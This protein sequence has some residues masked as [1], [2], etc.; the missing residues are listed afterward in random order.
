MSHRSEGDTM[1]E[2]HALQ[3][4]LLAGLVVGSTA[5]DLPVDP[6]SDLA[7]AAPPA[8]LGPMIDTGGD[9][10]ARQGSDITGEFDLTARVSSQFDNQ[11]VEVPM[12]AVADQSGEIRTGMATVELELRP[13]DAPQQ[14]GASTDQ[15]EPIDESGAFQATVTGFT[16]PADSS[17]MLQKD[18]TADVDLDAQIVDSD[19]FRGDSTITM[20][21]VEVSGSTIPEVVLEGPFTAHRPG[22]SCSG[23]SKGD[24]G[25]TADTD[26]GA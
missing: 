2:T 7:D 21:D 10:A 3:W 18:T 15:P 23:G 22:A 5:C 12:R 14:P 6:G 26:G 16:I 25:L 11:V 17:D 1:S 13:A 24:A 19:C 8:K 20:K 4:I 9:V